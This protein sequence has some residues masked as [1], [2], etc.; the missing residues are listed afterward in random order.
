MAGLADGGWVIAWQS[1]GQDGDSNG[2]FLRRY[3]GTGAA[4]GPDILVNATI[5]ASQEE[6]SVTALADG[7]FVVTWSSALEDGSGFGLYQRRYDATGATVGPDLRVNASSSG[8]Q[9]RSAVTALP[10]GGWIVAWQSDGQDGDGAGIYQRRYAATGADSL[11]VGQDLVLGSDADEELIVTEAALNTCDSIDGG[12]GTDT[13]DL[14]GAVF[15]FTGVSVLGIETILMTDAGG[16]LLGTTDKALAQLVDGAAGASDTLILTGDTFT[17]AERAALFAR[18]IE[19][20]TDASGSY[21]NAAPT[22]ITLS[23]SA[24]LENTP[25][26]T[27]VATLG[28]VDPDSPGGPFTFALLDDAGGLFALDGNALKIAAALNFEDPNAPKTFALTVQATDPGGKSFT[29]ALA[30]SLANVNEAPSGLS[31][32][33]ATA[34]ELSKAGTVVG[35]LSAADPDTGDALAY[36]LVDDAGGRFQIVGD[37]LQ[38]RN[39][40]KL[41]YEQEKSHAVTVRAVD[42]GDLATTKSFTVRVGNVGT[43]KTSGTSAADVIVGG[44]GRD[45][46]GGGGDRLN[47]GAGKD[48]LSGNSG[49]DAFL[50]TT[51]PGSSNVDVLRDVSSKDDAIWLEN[52]VFKGLGSGSLAKPRKLSSDAFHVGSAAADA[53]DRDIYDTATGSL[54]YDRDG[55]G[56][57]A[58]VKFAVV[59]KKTALAFHDFFVI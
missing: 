1:N 48:Q 27:V 43:E 51:K 58:A 33:A 8:N 34:K 59:A 32:S 3:D 11:T 41:D 35:S 47:G 23:A 13:L 30:L 44:G 52:A 55:T 26:G 37:Q 46:L 40:V 28:A 21:T 31:L 45:T 10:D 38:V 12:G 49:K 39:G 22:D 53:E 9:W 56:A 6:P 54:F 24:V 19:T 16:T 57:A 25:A 7:G 4:A 42:G 2:V 20:V 29:K 14:V 5:L 50:F 15:D 36:E 18:G 17:L